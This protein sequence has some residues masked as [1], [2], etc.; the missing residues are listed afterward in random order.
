MADEGS[1]LIV[2]DNLDNLQ[3]LSKILMEQGYDVRVANNGQMAVK[4]ASAD[5][6]DLILLDVIMP[7]LDGY[8]VCKKLKTIDTTENVPS[9]G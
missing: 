6:P 9:I 7:D 4:S 3:L 8:E 1:I 5:P 2:D